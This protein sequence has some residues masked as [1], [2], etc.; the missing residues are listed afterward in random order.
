MSVRQKI[1]QLISDSMDELERHPRTLRVGWSDGPADFTLEV[2]ELTTQ[3][4]ELT[5]QIATL[6]AII[7]RTQAGVEAEEPCAPFKSILAARAA[8]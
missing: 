2:Q 5:T 1:D 3:V 8:I 4:R 6:T 7:K